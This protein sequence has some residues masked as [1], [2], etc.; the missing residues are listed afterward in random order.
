VTV[1][2]GRYLPVACFGKLPFWPEF[3]EV[4]VTEPTA[5]HL[6]RWLHR[7]REYAGGL[8]A[9]DENAPDLPIKAHNRCLIE[10]SGAGELLAGVVRPSTDRGG[11][12][13]PFAVFTHFPR[14]IY[15]KHYALLTLAL[16]PVW[17]ALED[18][19]ELIRPANSEEEFRERLDAVEVPHP[20]NREETRAVH[21]RMVRESADRLFGREDGT[22]A[23][24]LAE[25]M[26]DVLLRLRK[27]GASDG[28]G[29]GL[30]V[31][32]DLE[33]A[34]FDAGWWID[35][36]NRQFRLRRFEPSVFIDGRPG[37]PNRLA[38]LKF[39]PLGAK[40]YPAIMG[41]DVA[42]DPLLRLVHGGSPAAG[43]TSAPVGVS[44]EDLLARKLPRH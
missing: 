22:D 23:G 37:L 27:L 10:L 14:R 18:A 39:G 38:V 33:E 35:L 13:F 20:A 11:R 21:R 40:D 44:F 19:W 16:A 9:D 8:Q 17:D 29:L 42:E 41:L 4:G 2:A 28:L 43:P 36:L 34:C 7:G 15:G 24:L 32:D 5:R 1:A 30:P 6:K 12:H 3:L 25:R 31:S 26:P